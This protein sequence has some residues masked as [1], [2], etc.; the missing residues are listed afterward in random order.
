VIV[1]GHHPWRE[2]QGDVDRDPERRRVEAA[3]RDAEAGQLANEQSLAEL[4]RARGVTQAQQAEALDVPQSQ[5]SRIEHQAALY[6]ST[7]AR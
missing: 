6:I 4:R 2:I 3:R 1:A 7:L 5:V